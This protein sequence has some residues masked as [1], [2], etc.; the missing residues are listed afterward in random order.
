M[1]LRISVQI[2]WNESIHYSVYA[3]GCQ[4]YFRMEEDLKN[5]RDFLD[6]WDFGGIFRGFWGGFLRIFVLGWTIIFESK[7]PGV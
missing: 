5:P 1:S 4:L 7:T 2:K 6:L 3:R